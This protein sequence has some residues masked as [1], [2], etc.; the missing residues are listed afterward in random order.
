MVAIISPSFSSHCPCWTSAQLAISL[1]RCIARACIEVFF[2]HKT[3]LKTRIVVSTANWAPWWRGRPHANTSIALVCAACQSRPFMV[4]NRKWVLEDYL[5][6]TVWGTILRGPRHPSVQWPQSR[7]NVSAVDDQVPKASK[8]CCQSFREAP[9]Q[10][11][12][13]QG[14]PMSLSPFSTLNTDEQVAAAQ[15]RVTKFEA[16]IQ[17]VGGD[18]PAATG[19]KEALQKAR[20][21]FFDP[22]NG[23][24]E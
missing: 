18:D 20:G 2:F 19:L 21:F 15:V 7:R 17:A 13:H 23:V 3:L 1:K 4:R 16:A 8:K 10:R 12:R 9:T 5:S 6:E 22:Q 24:E 11:D 14:I